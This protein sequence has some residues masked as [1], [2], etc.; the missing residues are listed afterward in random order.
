M[1][2]GLRAQ[3]LIVSS[4]LLAIPLL[5]LRSAREIEAFLV[6]T[7]EQGLA[8]TARDRKSVV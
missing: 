2:L 3:L 7:Q 6:E 5:G 1:R 4:L 8:A